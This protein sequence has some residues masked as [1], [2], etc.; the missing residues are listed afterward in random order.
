MTASWGSISRHNEGMD[1]IT[2]AFSTFFGA[3]VALLAERITRARDAALREEAA[4]NNLILDL[5]AKRAFVVSGDWEW[6]P[7]EIERVDG[8]IRH[9]RRLVRE[10]RYQLRP[11]SRGLVNLRKMTSAC[12]LFLEVSERGSDE[13]LK[14]A[15]KELAVA[16]AAQ[17]AGLHDLRPKRI[18]ADAPGSGAL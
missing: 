5:A 3:A 4:I 17:V 15:L 9:A 7:G 16:M 6:G 11:R 18:Y 8:S 13:D 2:I 12:N 14:F 1:F 10:T